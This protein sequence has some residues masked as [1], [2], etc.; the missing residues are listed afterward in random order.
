MVNLCVCWFCGSDKWRV[1]L[2]KDI[3][4]CFMQWEKHMFW[5]L[6]IGFLLLLFLFCCCFFGLWFLLRKICV[7]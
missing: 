3:Q 4:V 7:V 1:E 5:R 2:E 6:R